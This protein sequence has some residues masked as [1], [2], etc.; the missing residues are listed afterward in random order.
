[1]VFFFLET[2]Q[3]Q[4]GCYTYPTKSNYVVDLVLFQSKKKKKKKKR[5]QV[6]N[7]KL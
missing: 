7:M 3:L 5:F 6:R 1:M 2:I 4:F